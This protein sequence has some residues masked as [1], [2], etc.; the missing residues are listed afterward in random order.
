M[1]DRQ[2]LT[3][4]QRFML[5]HRFFRSSGFY[6]FFLRNFLRVIIILGA[7]IGLIFGLEHYILEDLRDDFLFWLSQLPHVGVWVVYAISETLLG[8]IPP[9]LF[10][11]WANKFDKP[12]LYL[13]LLGGISYGAG[14]L[15]Y[16]IGNYFGT[17][18]RVEHWLL[19]RYAIFVKRL[20]QWGGLLIIV[21]ALLPLPYSTVCMLAG[22]VKYPL[23][24]LALY[25]LTRIIRFYIYASFLLKIF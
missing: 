2:K 22:L 9:D 25:G 14:I 8:L 10:I 13:T 16:I 17:K 19:N 15:S 5:Y 1:R 3:N 11:I 12:I 7:I 24:K 23:P 18:K 6:R 21:A 4:W 20:R